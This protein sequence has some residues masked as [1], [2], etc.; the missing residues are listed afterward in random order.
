MNEIVVHTPVTYSNISYIFCLDY[1]ICFRLLL[2]VVSTQLLS[3]VARVLSQGV[4]PRGVMPFWGGLFTWQHWLLLRLIL[5]SSVFM[6]STRV[7]LEEGSWLLRVLESWL[8]LLGPCC[9]II[10]PLMLVSKAGFITCVSSVDYARF[11]M[12]RFLY[13]KLPALEGRGFPPP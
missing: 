1:V 4:Y 9:I 10:S 13:R 6:R 8:L 5:S 11:F 2:I 3:L 12:E 7:G